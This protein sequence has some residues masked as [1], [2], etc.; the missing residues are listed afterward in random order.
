MLG[1]GVI[2]AKTLTDAELMRPG[3][4]EQ[5]P[6]ALAKHLNYVYPRGPKLANQ[7]GSA[8]VQFVVDTTGK[9]KPESIVC[10]EATTRISRRRRSTR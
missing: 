1:K 6:I 4:I 3:P 5:K 9:A 7:S 8:L 10:M 2:A